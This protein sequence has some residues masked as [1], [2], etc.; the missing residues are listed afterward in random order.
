MYILL[1]CILIDNN[2]DRCRVKF[3]K[4]K[5]QWQNLECSGEI[6]KIEKIY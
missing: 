6:H 2:S 3:T 4:L 5:A 1:I